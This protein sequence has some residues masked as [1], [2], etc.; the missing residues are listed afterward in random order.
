MYFIL[1][2]L[3]NRI[4]NESSLLTIKFAGCGGGQVVSL[5]AFYSDNVSSS[6]AEDCFNC[7]KRKNRK[8]RLG[9]A[10]FQQTNKI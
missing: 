8:R 5:L 1:Q 10:L 9:R 6:L 2:K 7:L 3:D 4:A